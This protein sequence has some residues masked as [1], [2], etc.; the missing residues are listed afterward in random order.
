MPH[1]PPS[2][3]V[4]PTDTGDIQRVGE[5]LLG[6]ARSLKES[7]VREERIEADPLLAEDVDAD[8]H[9]REDAH[10]LGAHRVREGH[11]GLSR[12][13]EHGL[14]GL[15]SNN[16]FGGQG[17]VGHDAARVGLAVSAWL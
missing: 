5:D 12:V 13:R 17:V 8:A 14:G 1:A 9:G 11:A 3:A 2:P 15:L 4:S 16:R 6:D 10:E 7:A